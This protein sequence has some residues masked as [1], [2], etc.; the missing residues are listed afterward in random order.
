ML[1]LLGTGFGKC[2]GGFTLGGLVLPGLGGSLG[3]G[4]YSQPCGLSVGEL[5]GLLRDLLHERILLLL[6]LVDNSLLAV[7]LAAHLLQLFIEHL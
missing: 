1:Y 5:R 3:L 6:D 4:R 7:D 2:L